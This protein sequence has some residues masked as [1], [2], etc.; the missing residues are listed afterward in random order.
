MPQ[1]NYVR[2]NFP[3]AGG[4][5]RRKT[6]P[7]EARDAIEKAVDNLL[8][9]ILWTNENNCQTVLGQKK[10]IKNYTEIALAMH[11]APHVGQPIV[12]ISGNAL[13]VLRDLFNGEILGSYESVSRDE[14]SN[15]SG[16]K[17]RVR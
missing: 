1:E 6:S 7:E 9:R 10:T 16:G 5:R 12:Q 8:R 3:H 11:E 2:L 15:Q 13:L 4:R 14:Y 17:K